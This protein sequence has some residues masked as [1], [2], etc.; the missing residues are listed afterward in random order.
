MKYLFRR[1]TLQY[2]LDNKCKDYKSVQYFF[3][4]LYFLSLSATIILNIPLY[5]PRI[6]IGG[7]KQSSKKSD[8]VE[9]TP[10]V[11]CDTRFHPPKHILGPRLIKQIDETKIDEALDLSTK[12]LSDTIQDSKDAVNV[13]R[14]CPI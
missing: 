13:F 7:N 10:I 12:C 5:L 2:H 8:W 11:D 4:L 6:L 9:L 1:K 3:K 14:Y